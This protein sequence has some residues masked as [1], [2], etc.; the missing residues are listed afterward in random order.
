MLSIGVLKD[1]QALV[2]L[3]E[4]GRTENGLLGSLEAEKRVH[5]SG[6]YV[7]LCEE[8]MNTAQPRSEP[9]KSSQQRQMLGSLNHASK[10]TQRCKLGLV[11]TERLKF[12]GLSSSS[13][14]DDLK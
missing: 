6:F 5:I 14:V 4:I 12:R 8:L 11:R 2:R 10:F 1:G 9:M 13:C 3:T 7:T